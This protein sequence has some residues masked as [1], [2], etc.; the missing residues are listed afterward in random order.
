MV[1]SPVGV[2]DIKALSPITVT[3]LG[4]IKV[5]QVLLYANAQFGIAFAA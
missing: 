2:L 3:A 1:K 4:Q 5:V